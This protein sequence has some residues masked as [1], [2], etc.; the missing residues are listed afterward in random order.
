MGEQHKTRWEEGSS[1]AAVPEQD[2]AREL[3]AAGRQEATREAAP[4]TED[5]PTD[6]REESG[7][8]GIE[9]AEEESDDVED[10]PDV[11]TEDWKTQ[12]GD[13]YLSTT[14]QES[15]VSVVNASGRMGVP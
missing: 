11:W 2:A 15:C 12:P 3:H 14:T 13:V 9:G 6:P 8:R 4:A 7:T 5:A 10:G 1:R